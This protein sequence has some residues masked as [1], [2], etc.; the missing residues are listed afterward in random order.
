ME[1][2]V[3]TRVL[4]TRQMT[5][6]CLC[7][8]VELS[9]DVGGIP[10]PEA[11]FGATNAWLLVTVHTEPIGS[12]V[13]EVPPEGLSGEQI[14]AMVTQE[15]AVAIADRIH[16]DAARESALSPFLASRQRILSDAPHMAVMVCT[17]ERPERLKTCLESLV[18]QE[19]P[20]FSVLVIDNFPASDRTKAVVDSLSSPLI[21]YVLQ[22]EKGLCR[23]KNLAVDLAV[24]MAGE[25]IVAS[26]DDDETADPHWLAELARG[27]AEHPEADA[28]AGI[29]APG[30]LET[31]A[32]VWFEQYGGHN[33]LRGFTPAVF[34]PQTAS[35]Q[36]PLYPLPSFGSGGNVAFRTSALKRVGGFDIA[37]GPGTPSMS[38]EDTRIFTD[39]LCSGGTVVYQPTAVTRHFH[40][41][42]MEELRTQMHGYGVGLTAFYAS[43]VID[44]PR[45][46]PA[47]IRLLPTAYRDMFRHD[48]LQS[49]GLPSDF[50]EDLLRTKRRG[51]FVGPMSY[52][53]S[54]V[55]AARSEREAGKV[56]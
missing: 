29:M 55:E 17:R 3:P 31:W 11:L 50:P 21:T 12:M 9:T 4:S 34:S 54:R 28:V 23:A 41:R 1:T 13:V 14:K 46:I 44:R 39:L 19:Y 53:R 49:S 25:G 52:L 40:R 6:P 27:F 15:F 43:L 48:G 18:A 45:C 20:N 35:V 10:A 47:L 37:L 56:Q 38:N 33:K 8:D 36:S 2:L 24:E 30:E 7:V 22:P 5:A 16:P 26:I 32:Q 42:S 51:M